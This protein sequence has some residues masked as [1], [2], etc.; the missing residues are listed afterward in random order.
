M[1]SIHIVLIVCSHIYLTISL[2]VDLI[3]E[4]DYEAATGS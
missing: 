4:L 1:A 3:P 2:P